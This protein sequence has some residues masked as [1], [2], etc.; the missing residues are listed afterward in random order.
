MRIELL[1]RWDTE[2]GDRSGGDKS[3]SS[4]AEVFSP[5]AKAIEGIEKPTY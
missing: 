2:R 1:A 3:I 5:E 4:Q